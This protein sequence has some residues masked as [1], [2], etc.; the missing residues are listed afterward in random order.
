MPTSENASIDPTSSLLSPPAAKTPKPSIHAFFTPRRALGPIP[1]NSVN[2]R[3]SRIHLLSPD[4]SPSARGVKRQRID[5][6]PIAKRVS[7]RPSVLF[8][9]DVV[10]ED[11]RVEQE[12]VM[13]PPRQRVQPS[14]GIRA[15]TRS[16]GGLGMGLGRAQR[17]IH[18]AE[19][20]REV[21]SYYSRPCDRLQI[22]DSEGMP[23]L[24][25]S[26]EACN[27]NSLVAIGCESGLVRLVESAK[28]E[29]P[30]FTKS[31]LTLQ[32]HDNAIFDMSWSPDD[33]LLATASGDQTG[34]IIDVTQQRT[35][36]QLRDHQNTLKQV[37]FNP[38]NPSL[39]ATG[40]RDGFL[41]IWDT[42]VSGMT[43]TENNE[44]MTA[45]RPVQS[46]NC[47]NGT[48]NK[49]IKSVSVT[50]AI[51]LSE[52][53]VA[54][55]TEGTSYIRLWDLKS[56][57]AKRRKK[58][59]VE[60]S[61]LPPHHNR[62]E[63]RHFGITCLMLSP[64]TQRLYAVCKD[65]NVYTYSSNHLAMGPLH[66]Y[67]HPKYHA[68]TFYVKGAI[69]RDGR[70]LAVGS[71]DS[72]VALFPTDEQYFNSSLYHGYAT[73]AESGLKIGKGAVMVRGHEK[74][75]TDVT[76]TKEGE[77]VSIS[78][79]MGARCWRRGGRVAEK[80]REGGE[81]EGRRHEWGWGEL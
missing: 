1:Q 21:V 32:C 24:P 66:A 22:Q 45:L 56:T 46:I 18:C 13:P 14:M 7:D 6:S 17:R 70:T 15:L 44:T 63:K 20:S 4:D 12:L 29:A 75:V 79:D 5:S 68:A 23:T 43:V 47:A 80:M 33:H 19:W 62:P 28:D 31:Y 2:S 36:F 52:N 61:G 73:T 81:E 42:R 72:V 38:F 30:G 34:R 57:G 39:L 55:S 26:T 53:R 25:F 74:E 67:S 11:E 54:T 10:E 37:N 77:V 9:E 64:D 8:G 41:N 59:P 50:A 65:R 40:A 71:S 78:D 48:T 58:L 49:T 69:S 76:W 27:T 51:W 35:L 16:L 60:T 3:S